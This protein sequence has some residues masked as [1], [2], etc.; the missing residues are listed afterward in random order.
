MVSA[1]SNMVISFERQILFIL[2]VSTTSGGVEL[3]ANGTYYQF[4][5]I[6]SNRQQDN[7]INDFD[8][9]LRHCDDIFLTNAYYPHVADIHTLN[10]ACIQCESIVFHSPGCFGNATHQTICRSTTNKCFTALYNNLLILVRGC[11][12]EQNRFGMSKLLIRTVPDQIDVC[13]DRDRCNEKPLIEEMC[14][15][16][17]YEKHKIIEFGHYVDETLQQLC[18]P[19]LKPMGCYA[20]VSED[21]GMVKTGCMNNMSVMKIKSNVIMR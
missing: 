20:L 7:G 17:Q 10:I 12:S 8:F 11:D 18:S 6:R 9:I 3:G 14:A 13:T 5:C 4:K 21:G 1:K 19:S 15:S 16:E 2:F